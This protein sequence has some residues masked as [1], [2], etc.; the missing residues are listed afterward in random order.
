MRAPIAPTRVLVADD[1]QIVRRGLATMIQEEPDLVV[2]GEAADGVEAVEQ[3]RLL[4]PDVVLMDVRMPRLDGISAT[5]EIMTAGTARAVVIVTTFD[6]EE[7]LLDGVR[8]GAAGFLLK[9]AG[10]ELLAAAVRA[11]L[12]GD[13][14]ID[15][16]MTRSLLEHKLRSTARTARQDPRL[17]TLSEREREVLA[18]VA[19]GDSNAEIARLLWVSEATVKTHISSIL[20]KIDANNRVQAAVF[21]YESGFIRPGWLE[22]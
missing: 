16:S 1:Q 13:A 4:V 22:G 18:A 5:R 14:L 3:A 8:A 2:V 20:S 10:P 6:D 9:D 12:A 21:A 19:L 17:S 11:A 15:P 7:Y